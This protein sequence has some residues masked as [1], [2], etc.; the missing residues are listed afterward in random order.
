MI[1][2][3]TLSHISEAERLETFTAIPTR[4]AAVGEEVE[5]ASWVA[6]EGLMAVAA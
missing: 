6:E 2:A 5:E 4:A 1:S 3:C